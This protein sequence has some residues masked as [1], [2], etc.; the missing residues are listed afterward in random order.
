MGPG[1]GGF[2]QELIFLGF[3]WFTRMGL[4]SK[5]AGCVLN[6]ACEPSQHKHLLP[7][8]S[9][10]HPRNCSQGNSKTPSSGVH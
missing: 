3:L 9:C 6:H 7:T 1:P 2:Q 5:E 8:H 10:K 4:G